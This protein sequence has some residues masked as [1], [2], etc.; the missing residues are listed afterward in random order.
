VV[1]RGWEAKVKKKKEQVLRG[2]PPSA[3]SGREGKGEGH[4]KKKMP[5]PSGWMDVPS[6]RFHARER[7]KHVEGVCPDHRGRG[8]DPLFRGKK[9]GRFLG[10]KSRVSKVLPGAARTG[11][12]SL[13]GNRGY[14][15][16]T[17]GGKEL[18]E[19]GKR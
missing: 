13:G 12:K 15:D 9:S 11:N 1:S 18:H 17:K 19:W 10:P 2:S 16:F 4:T 7:D 8:E 6:E 5:P 14:T 3:I